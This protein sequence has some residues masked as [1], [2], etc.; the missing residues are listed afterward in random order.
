MPPPLINLFGKTVIAVFLLLLLHLCEVPMH[1]ITSIVLSL[2]V[3]VTAML[4]SALADIRQDVTVGDSP[5][6]WP[7]AMDDSACLL[8][9]RAARPRMSKSVFE[10]GIPIG[11]FA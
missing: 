3:L 5:G 4:S 11:V 6:N 9:W 7:R 10:K 2:V 8:A 1:R